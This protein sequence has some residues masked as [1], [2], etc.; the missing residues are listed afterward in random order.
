VCGFIASRVV[1]FLLNQGHQVVGID[2]INDAYDIRLKHWRLEH[3][4]R[5]SGFEFYKLDICDRPGL[6]SMFDRMPAFDGV[7]NLA[8]RA[9]VR[10][11]LQDP[12]IYLETNITG[13]LN[14][15][16]E[17]RTRHVGKFV[18]ASTSSLYGGSNPVPYSEEMNTSCPLSP[19]AASKKAA[20]SL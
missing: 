14:L 2:N 18:L 8:A 3:L 10:Q 17:C 9:G 12:W 16:E 13:T 4:T 1:E 20:E 11:S 5:T 6:R 7:I 15:L 19:Y